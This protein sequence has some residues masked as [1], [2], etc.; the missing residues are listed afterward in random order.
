M[1]KE[2]NKEKTEKITQ[3][4]SIYYIFQK[5]KRWSHHPV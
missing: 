2:R 5:R 3:R 4:K 1:G